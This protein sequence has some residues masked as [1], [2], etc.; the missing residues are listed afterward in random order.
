MKELAHKISEWASKMIR[1]YGRDCPGYWE[2][3]IPNTIKSVTQM[4]AL[5]A[6]LKT[7]NSKPD[8]R[9][10]VYQL[11]VEDYWNSGLGVRIRYTKVNQ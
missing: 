6:E 9:G 7:Y 2:V 11:I 10:K 3:E 1:D 5:N 8:E 4:A